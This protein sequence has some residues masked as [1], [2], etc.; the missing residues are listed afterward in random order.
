M[1]VS[2]FL[3]KKNTVLGGVKVWWSIVHYAWE[4]HCGRRILVLLCSS[5]DVCAEQS[6]FMVKALL[7]LGNM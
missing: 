6:F 7:F 2:L 3:R 4:L 5:F 1:R